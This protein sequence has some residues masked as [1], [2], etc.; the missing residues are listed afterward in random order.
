MRSH[1]VHLPLA[2]AL[3]TS[4]AQAVLA[5]PPQIN[6][7]FPFGVQRGVATDV[8]VSGGNLGASARLIA[9][10]SVQVEPAGENKDAA[11]WAA[12]LTVAADTPVG[13]YPVRLVT[14]DGISNPFLFSVGQ[15]PQVAEAEDNSTFETAQAIPTPAVVEGQSAGNDVEFFKFTGRKGQRIVVDAQCARI[16]STVD[17]TLRLTTAGRTYVASADDSPGLLTDA[18]LVAILP[19]DTD[20]I[21]ELSDSRYQGGNQPLYRLLVGEVPTA[22]EVYPLGGRQGETVGLEVRGG[23]LPGPALA[24]TALTAF[25]GTE[26]HRPRIEGRLLGLEGSKLEL[27]SIPP[28]V[29]SD[30]PELREPAN[31][32]AAPVKAVFPVVFNGRI[33]PAGDEDRFVLAVTPGQ[34]LHIEVTAADLGST[35]DGVLQVLNPTGG[36][37]T[38]ADDTT[39]QTPGRNNRPRQAIV[40]P[41][42]ALDVTVPAGVNE[43]TLALKDLQSRGGTGFPYRI[44]VEPKTAGFGLSLND[45]QVS[46]PKG[47]TVAVPVT[48][49]RKGYNG[50]ITLEVLD[51]PAGLTFRPGIV[52]DGQA[53]GVLT[54]SA[55]PDSNF[56]PVTL[57]VV[58][59]AKNGDQTIVEPAAKSVVFAQQANMPTNSMTQVGLA[60]APAQPTPATLE[61]PAEPVEV[62]HGYGATVTVKAVRADKA[63]GALALAPLPLPPGL[64]VPAVSIAEKAADAAATVNVATDAPLGKMTIGLTG[65]GKLIDKERTLAVPAITLNVVRPADVELGSTSLEIKAGSTVEL[66]GKVVRRGPFKEPVTIKVEGLP[67]G[68]KAE[69]LT[70]APEA[71]E[72]AVPIIAEPAAAAAMAQAR[73]AVAFQVNMKDY[74]TPPASVAVKVLPQ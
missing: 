12:K 70:V 29:V 66:K 67:A 13:T 61:A 50:P 14:D 58:G 49:A 42:P 22:D 68:L 74:P 54:L 40:S 59:T 60:A 10:F 25:P 51:P 71:A 5:D 43:I 1:R 2:I 26:L 21:I 3:V 62:V 46:V 48:I 27:E 35:L 32:A 30:L 7:I 57:K 39:E 8:T 65:K 45:A 55:S 69:P 38:T 6:A 34:A 11:K 44:T 52:A 24:A 72:F 31:P 4:A 15:L 56:G 28:L 23:T 63:D 73:I 9:P 37:I 33:D 19:E 64:A 20:Y 16:G 53:V 17:P 47:G 41:D 18:R 36:V